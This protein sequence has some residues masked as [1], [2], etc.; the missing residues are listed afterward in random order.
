VSQVAANILN[1]GATVVLARLLAPA[2]F[3][4]VAMVTVIIGFTIMLRDLGLSSAT[5]QRE[6]VKHH[7]VST[8]FW[9]NVAAGVFL[10]LLIMACA[11]LIASFY[12]RPELV[13][14]SLALATLSLLDGLSIQHQALLRRQ[15]RMGLLAV[16]DLVS[17][18]A[19]IVTAILLAWKGA[20]FW[21]LVAMQIVSMVIKTGMSW[22]ASGWRPTRAVNLAEVR[23][24]LAF[25]GQLTAARMMNYVSHNVDKL[26]IGKFW[27]AQDLGIYTKAFSGSVVPFQKA[28]RSL[29]RVAVP[30][31][32]RLQDDPARFRTY[33]QTAVLLLFTCALPVT[34]AII[35]E[36][37]AVV[38][39]IL[40]EQWLAMV[41]LLQ[42]LAPVAV[43]ELLTQAVRWALV[44]MGRGERL[45]RWRSAEAIV[46]VIGITISL[47]W[48]ITGIAWGLLIVNVVLAIPALW[49]CFLDS[50]L[51][52]KDVTEVIWKP[53]TATLAA[54]GIVVGMRYMGAVGINV[55]TD[56]AIEL[57]VLGV[58]YL[59]FWIA[60]PGGL[61]TLRRLS[62]LAADL[63]RGPVGGGPAA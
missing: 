38:R 22:F 19:G 20:G 57:G 6:D 53:L 15:L 18:F 62:R 2:D 54:A 45:L 25:G 58:A 13:G 35:L 56:F 44:S 29:S 50:P 11:P 34:A 4:I 47:R 63:R 16:I 30:T 46:K 55:V 17:Q 3:G 12:D 23:S 1:L 40:G 59:A 31:L 61:A 8:L 36:A 43:T 27:S 39:I 42:I 14:V 52:I 49:Y 28:I 51:R 41:P 10:T 21:S 37:E 60:L 5:I 26:L 32:S 48:G 24:M 7:H 33:F 9:V